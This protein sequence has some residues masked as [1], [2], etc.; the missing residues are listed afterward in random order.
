MKELTASFVCFSFDVCAVR[1]CIERVELKLIYSLLSV[2]R[3]QAFLEQVLDI[4]SVEAK[5]EHLL[6][7]LLLPLLH[8]RVLRAS[9]ELP[10]LALRENDRTPG[11]LDDRGTAYPKLHWVRLDFLFF[12]KLFDLRRDFVEDLLRQRSV[13][14][15]IPTERDKLH[16]VPA[17]DFASDAVNEL[18]TRLT[19][20]DLELFLVSLANGDHDD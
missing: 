14:I 15:F 17:A 7:K 9:D 5:F 20:E 1:L 11:L 19:V 18:V 13:I 12:E 10:F 16:D 6:H 4:T 2:H 3:D 8:A